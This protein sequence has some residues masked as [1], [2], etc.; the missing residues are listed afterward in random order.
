M[1]PLLTHS[2]PHQ[3]WW[4]PSVY[5]LRHLRVW[6]RLEH[7]TGFEEMPTWR[8]STREQYTCAVGSPQPEVQP[9][10]GKCAD[11]QED[12]QGEVG[13]KQSLSPRLSCRRRLKG[14]TLC[15]WSPPITRHSRFTL[16]ML[17]R[18]TLGATTQAGTACFVSGPSQNLRRCPRGW[19]TVVESGRMQSR[20]KS[21][22]PNSATQSART[23]GRE[24][25]CGA[26]TH[27]MTW[28]WSLHVVTKMTVWWVPLT[29]KAVKFLYN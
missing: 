11:G 10:K 23:L 12:M 22:F 3:D 7:V 19:G 18:N 15:T 6:H 25:W 21:S 2:R 13:R 28:R 5:N 4:G 14:V 17:K 29:T 24:S 9:S 1:R 27:R 8:A 26:I 16:S 20:Q